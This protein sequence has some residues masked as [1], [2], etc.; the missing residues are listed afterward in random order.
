MKTTLYTI[1]L[2]IHSSFLYSNVNSNIENYNI[3]LCL[4]G[5]T[6]YK[7]TINATSYVSGILRNIGISDANFVLVPCRNIANAYATIYRGRRYILYDDLF[8]N[9]LSRPTNSNYFFNLFVLAHEIGHHLNGHTLLPS[10][11]IEVSQNEELEADEFAGFIVAKMGGNRDHIYKIL[12]AI[13]HPE[14]NYSSHP[15]YIRRLSAALYGFYKYTSDIEKHDRELLQ[16]Y[17]KKVE[18]EIQQ[19]KEQIRKESESKIKKYEEEIKKHYIR[20]ITNKYENYQYSKCVSSARIECVNY[21]LNSDTKYLDNAIKLYLQATSIK[22]DLIIIV[23]LANAYQE[24]GNFENAQLYFQQAY[25]LSKDPTYLLLY[26]DLFNQ[27]YIQDERFDKEIESIDYFQIS[28]YNALVALSRYYSQK[29]CKTKEINKKYVTM[30]IDILNYIKDDSLYIVVG[31]EHIS[32]M[33]LAS[34]FSDLSINSNALK[35]YQ[36]SY[37]YIKKAIDLYEIVKESNSIDKIGKDN[38]FKTLRNMALIETYLTKWDNVL[39][40]TDLIIKEK[41]ENANV[42]YCRGRAYAGLG[43]HRD[44]I[45]E[46]TLAL[47]MNPTDYSCYYYRGLSNCK[48]SENIRQGIIDLQIACS[49]GYQKACE[50]LKNIIR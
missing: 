18:F 43:K 19:Y 20:E 44:A 47:K 5:Y 28:N 32:Y 33:N 39:Q 6:N 30:A 48:Y 50:I 26:W 41:A 22:E 29:G 45:N 8:L 17:Q 16:Q 42:H 31:G 46:Y 40:T 24:L 34:I 2:L 12:E 25:R 27:R 10:E 7:S 49:S 13:P 21:G 37:M 4:D 15:T 1:I 36:T 23:D 35:D 11:S 9:E 14:N 38:Y 3:G